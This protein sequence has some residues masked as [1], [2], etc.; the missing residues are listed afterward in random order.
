MIDF[1]KK[2]LKN[3]S[4]LCAS[5]KLALMLC[6]IVAGF[7]CKP[8]F[9]VVCA[10]GCIFIICENSI[11][12]FYI[13][14]SLLPFAFLD[15]CKVNFLKFSVNFWSIFVLVFVVVLGIKTFIQFIKKEKHFDY[16]LCIPFAVFAVYCVIS[17]FRGM[18]LI[19]VFWVF[20][21]LILFYLFIANRK[22]FDL[23]K[24]VLFYVFGILLSFIGFFKNSIPSLANE[25]ANYY[26]DGLLRFSG[27]FTNPNRLYF[28]CI[29]GMC[30]I[31]ILC[32]YGKL[33]KWWLGLFF[34]LTF[35]GIYSLSKTFWV[36]FCVLIVIV[37]VSLLVKVNKQKL[38]MLL[39]IC[40][41]LFLAITLSFPYASALYYRVL[42]ANNVEQIQQEA[43]N[44]GTENNNTEQQNPG[45]ENN[46]TEQQNPGS[47]N[48]NTEQPNPEN[49]NENKSDDEEL[50]NSPKQ[51]FSIDK[52]TTGR[53]EI[54]KQY[55]KDWKSSKTTLLFGYGLGSSDILNE[56]EAHNG[57]IQMLYEYGIFGALII[58]GAA[59]YFMIHLKVFKKKWFS[60][61]IMPLVIM[62]MMLMVESLLFT[63]SWIFVM[64]LLS[65]FITIN[66]RDEYG[67]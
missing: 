27:L 60:L 67:S 36:C 25:I 59:I 51:E 16:K 8:L 50:D 63:I 38:L 23:T 40:V 57:Y 13:L 15:F 24:G 3:T 62:A 30:F 64:I 9:I 29:F 4:Y 14:V 66:G 56:N 44:P 46:N 28:H 12:S 52:L 34:P 39:T 20:M 58:V 65:Y 47:E 54:W 19:T 48:N 21:W 18:P 32:Y 41:S 49:D 10:L 2:F 43:S 37:I 5:I 11:N 1:Y 33:K 42:P 53:Y 26:D 22:D 6:F 61:G 45:S 35:L 55:L 17:I 31:Y 7:F